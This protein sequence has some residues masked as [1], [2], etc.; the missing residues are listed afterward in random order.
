MARIQVGNYIE[1]LGLAPC[2]LHKVLF[3][4][5]IPGHLVCVYGIYIIMSLCRHKEMMVTM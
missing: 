2:F 3:S 5:L 4:L 1:I